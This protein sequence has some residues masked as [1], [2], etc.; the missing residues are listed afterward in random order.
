MT[1][2]ALSPEAKD[3]LRKLLAEEEPGACV[4]LREY[5]TGSG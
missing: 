2:I 5:K 3:R 1:A 4:R